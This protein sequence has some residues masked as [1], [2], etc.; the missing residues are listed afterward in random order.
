MSRAWSPILSKKS[1]PV[2]GV[3]DA[4]SALLAEKA[5][6]DVLYLSGAAMSVAE[7]GV[8][9]IGL[10][11]LDEV[12]SVVRRTSPVVRRPILVDADTGFGG[13]L[14]VVRA[15]RELEAAG[16]AGIQIED[17]K[18]PKRCGHLSGK[19][20]IPADE[21]I[22]KIRLAAAARRNRSFLIVAR[23]DARGVTGMKDALARAAAYR[24]AGADILF[25]EALQSAAEFRAF[26]R[27]KTLGYLLANMTEF[28][29]SPA[30]TCKDL[31]RLGFRLVLFPVTA[32]RV[33][34][35]AMDRAYSDMKAK[36]NN[37]QLLGRMQSRREL[38]ELN[39]YAEY[40]ARERRWQQEA[41]K[42]T[43][44]NRKGSRKG[45]I[46]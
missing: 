41:V 30:L 9:D 42:I 21:M 33:A 23:T 34:A 28:G 15:V 3:Y 11:T 18:F 2:A 27:K 44:A 32:F 37:Q 46:L 16:A 7:L 1:V 10:L 29:R 13:E 8:P 14:N 36:G 40:D 45:S 35:F 19:S 38:Y 26:G 5:G 6:F 31:A 43:K 22:A 24:K 4:L 17:Q 39:R 20:L 25:P 12:T